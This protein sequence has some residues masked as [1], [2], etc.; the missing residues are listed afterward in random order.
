[1][2]RIKKTGRMSATEKAL[3]KRHALE[4][5]HSRS[6]MAPSKKTTL[7]SIAVKFYRKQLSSVVLRAFAQ[8]TKMVPM[9]MTARMSTAEEV[10]R[11]Q[12]SPKVPGEFAPPI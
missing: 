1:M 2:T 9:K 10:C 4:E 12:P 11:K 5:D 8:S 3:Q 7:E 6:E